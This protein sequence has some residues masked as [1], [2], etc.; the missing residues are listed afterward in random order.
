MGLL[1]D[2]ASA[3]HIPEVEL[4]RARS[5]GT[6]LPLI[7]EYFLLPGG[8]QHDLVALAA[9]AGV[10]TDDAARVWRALGLPER[11]V[12]DVVFRDSDVEALELFVRTMDTVSDT[13]VH[14]ARVISGAVARIAEVMVDEMWDTHFGGGAVSVAGVEELA[15]GGFDMARVERLLMHLLRR[16]LVASIYRRSTVHQ[17]PE[18]PAHAV[19][20]ADL[21]GYTALSQR[22]PTPELANLIVTFERV[23]H[24]VATDHGGW[25]VKTIGDEVMFA[26]TEPVAAA[27]IAAALASEELTPSLPPR[28]VAVAWGPVLAR[29]GDCFGPTVNRAARLVSAARPGEVLVDDELRSLVDDRFAVSRTGTTDLKDLGPTELWRLDGRRD[30]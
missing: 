16:Q 19:G 4:D 17:R 23:T 6:V 20:F 14:E 30:P 13:F 1:E 10:P 18:G 9:K 22:L 24:E 21:V 3:L 11:N 12:G 8:R 28:R 15:G 26:A 5:A 2:M 7:A 25:I 29:E 27:D